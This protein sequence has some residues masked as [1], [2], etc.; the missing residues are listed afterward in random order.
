MRYL[1]A[2]SDR[3][4]DVPATTIVLV[5]LGTPDAPRSGPVRRY[6]GQFLAD[7]RIIELPRWLWRMILHGFILRTRPR[8]SA[9]AY[10]QI[11]TEA[12]SP[13]LLGTQA[14][15]HRLQ[16]ALDA[17]Q[18]GAVQVVVAMRYGNPGIDAV[19]D[20]LARQGA[21]RVLVVALFPQYSGTTTGSVMDAVGKALH[22]WRN[23]PELRVAGDY[24]D[25]PLHIEALARSVERHWQD[26]GRADR[27]LLSFHGI[28]QRYVN[29]GDLYLAQCHTTARLLR[30]RLQMAE[31]EF[32]VVF[33]SRLGREPWLMPYADIRL[34]ELA[35]EGVGRVQVMCPGFAVDCLETLEEIAIRN[36]QDF[37]DAGG[38]EL[39]YIA[40]LNDSDDQVTAMLDFVGTAGSGWGGVDPTAR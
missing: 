40:A 18:P 32:E 9:H 34:L 16:Q 1:S 21:R 31:S 14:L 24:H 36:R 4:D 37:I 28:P 33:Q 17:R 6:L 19:F 22:R 38:K 20:R 13:L 8:Q 10:A 27:L 12:G 29:Q 23:V 26:K 5:N 30:E 3:S 2:A 25:Q 7:P 11:W 39:E 15:G 35:R